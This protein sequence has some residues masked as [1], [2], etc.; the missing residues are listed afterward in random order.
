MQSYFPAIGAPALT[1]CIA[2]YQRLGC[3][4]PHVEIT[5]RAFEAILDIFEYTGG[6]DRRYA[7][8]QVCAPPPVEA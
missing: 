8:D 6:I 4:T 3:W 1:D 5:P 2:V 7:W